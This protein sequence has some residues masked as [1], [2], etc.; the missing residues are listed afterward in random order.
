M[1]FREM[2]PRIQSRAWVS[3]VV[4]LGSTAL[5][6]AILAGCGPSDP[7]DP[8]AGDPPGGCYTDFLDAGTRAPRAA[9]LGEGSGASFQAYEAGQ[10]V[11]L[12]S[13]FQGGYMVTPSVRVDAAGGAGAEA[14]FQVSIKN[15]LTDVEDVA[16]GL[17]TYVTFAKS[18]EFFDVEGIWDLIAMD[19][20]PLHGKTLVLKATVTGQDFEATG[21]ATVVIE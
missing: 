12:V 4:R 16:P 11:T 9:V 18:G 21:E 13:G 5:A 10:K 1:A 19:D 7:I 15:V 3:D 17:Q 2:L 20:D 14:C 8:T 6:A